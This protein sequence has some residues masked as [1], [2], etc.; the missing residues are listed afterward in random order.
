MGMGKQAG[1]TTSRT[2]NIKNVTN[3]TPGKIEEQGPLQQFLLFFAKICGIL[4]KNMEYTT[5]VMHAIIAADENLRS[6]VI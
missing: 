5:V 6:M 4:D 3:E 2:S 1:D